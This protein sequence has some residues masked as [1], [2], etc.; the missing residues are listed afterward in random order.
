MEQVCNHHH[1][2]RG[3]QLE[4]SRHLSIRALRNDKCGCGKLFDLESM[5]LVSARH[6]NRSAYNICCRICC[7]F[8]TQVGQQQY[9]EYGTRP[10]SVKRQCRSRRRCRT[11]C[12][13]TLQPSKRATQ[14]ASL[15]LRCFT[16][17]LASIG[18]RTI[19]PSSVAHG[20]METT[21]PVSIE[22]NRV[23]KRI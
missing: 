19:S 22:P 14:H 16:F 18:S 15:Q 21:R 17:A 1:T 2:P 13:A 6:R 23:T 7:C 4:G 8:F 9:R 11:V 12:T 5:S 3:D 10:R 20:L